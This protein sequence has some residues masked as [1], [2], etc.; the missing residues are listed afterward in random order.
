MAAADARGLS[1]DAFLRGVDAALEAGGAAQTAPGTAGGAVSIMTIHRSKGWNSPSWC[2]PNASGALISAT[3]TSPCCCTLCWAWACACARGEGG[4]YE[5]APH[6][7]VR[8]AGL[9]EAVD[10]EMRIL[11]VA[12]TRAEG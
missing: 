3:A 12:L 6:A 11:Y 9:R 10:E 7:S 5:T 2:W 8:L 1:L 4:L